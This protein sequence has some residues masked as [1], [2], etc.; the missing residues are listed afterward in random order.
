MLEDFIKFKQ[1]ATST[2]CQLFKRLNDNLFKSQ[3]GTYPLWLSKKINEIK[4]LLSNDSALGYHR[5]VFSDAEERLHRPFWLFI[6]GEGKFGKST[7]VNALFG[8]AIAEV[9]ELPRT[10]RFDRF[11]QVDDNFCSAVVEHSEI[12]ADDNDLKKVLMQ[13]TQEKHYFKSYA[14]QKSLRAVLEN[15][16]QKIE[17]NPDYESPVYAVEWPISGKPL[18]PNIA[19]IDTPGL[20]QIFNDSARSSILNHQL[21]LNIHQADAILWLVNAA[22]VN[23]AVTLTYMKRFSRYGSPIIVLVN[24]MDN[25]T[26]KDRHRILSMAEK[27]YQE[28][29]NTILPISAKLGFK[30][31]TENR[32][33]VLQDSNLLVLKELILTKFVFKGMRIRNE[34]TYIRLHEAQREFRRIQNKELDLIRSNR[35]TYHLIHKSLEEYLYL[36]E[37]SGLQL[38]QEPYK[39]YRSNMEEYLSNIDLHHGNDEVRI[40][41][42]ER[43]FNDNIRHSRLQTE[44]RLRQQSLQFAVFLNEHPYFSNEYDLTGELRRQKPLKEMKQLLVPEMPDVTFHIDVNTYWW[45]RTWTAALGWLSKSAKEK[46]RENSRIEK[47]QSVRNILINMLDEKEKLVIQQF[48]KQMENI[49]IQLF[50]DL[51]KELNSYYG[52]LE[53]LESQISDKAN[54]LNPLIFKNIYIEKFL[55]YW[56]K[57]GE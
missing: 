44:Q 15:E 52:S 23:S 11:R 28:Y 27:H 8:Q 10:W 32:P 5:E 53:E 14:D 16:L 56:K 22:T 57:K 35:N 37:R 13:T 39:K 1:Q 7:L 20:N 3:P 45:R 29:S 41:V 30:G 25:F 40:I 18:F 2:S 46:Y 55:E 31:V 51:K 49:Q 6:V 47:R 43:E 26:H 33:D 34:V 21:D 50:S 17:L 42:K 36:Q 9:D 54:R 24:G 38:L 19:L 4:P 48:K 12:K